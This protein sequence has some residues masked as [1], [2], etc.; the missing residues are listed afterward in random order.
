MPN[1][2]TNPV[3]ALLK[4]GPWGI[5]LAAFIYFGPTLVDVYR[6]HREVSVEEQKISDSRLERMVDRLELK[7]ASMDAELQSNR[8]QLFELT[9]QVRIDR[10]ADYYA[11]IAIWRIDQ[12]GRLKSWNQTFV[13]LIFKPVGIA[14][15]TAR[16]K[17]WTE[18]FGDLGKSYVTDDR[19]V[20][21]DGGI[22][23][24]RT[25]FTLDKE[26]NKV[27]WETTKWGVTV[28]GKKEG[29]KGIG[30]PINRIID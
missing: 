24:L 9:I 3:S 6:V 26:G 23:V 29:L 2:N 5:L 30:V 12:Q 22:S 27:F 7:V 17:T 8:R 4:F 18:I 25:L 28:D 14:P 11:P 10:A 21:E 20:L 1:T 19:R 16:N 13:D 15:E